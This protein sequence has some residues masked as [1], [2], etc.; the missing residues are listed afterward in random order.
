MYKR[1]SI[2]EDLTPAERKEVKALSL[3]ADKRNL[4]KDLESHV[5]RVRGSS[6]NGFFLKKVVKR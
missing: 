4:D 5:W 1:I 6:K 2:A 3:E